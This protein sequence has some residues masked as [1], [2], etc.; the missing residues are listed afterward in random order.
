MDSAAILLN[1]YRSGGNLDF[2]FNINWLNGLF[3]LSADTLTEKI[4]ELT[5][6]I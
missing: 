5:G 1:T 6:E 3:I 4:S 2:L